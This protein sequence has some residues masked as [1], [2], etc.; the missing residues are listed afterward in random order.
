MKHIYTVT[1]ISKTASSS[2]GP[3]D[4]TGVLATKSREALLMQ[5]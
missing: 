5:K 1:G 2:N 3:Y 4:D